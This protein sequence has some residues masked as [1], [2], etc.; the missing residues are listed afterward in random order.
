MVEWAFSKKCTTISKIIKKVLPLHP[1]SFKYCNGIVYL[2][3]YSLLQL[4]PFGIV[5]N[6]RVSESGAFSLLYN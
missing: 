3:K 5:G 6:C 1:I 4:V 2:Y